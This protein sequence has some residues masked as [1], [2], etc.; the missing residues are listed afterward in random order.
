MIETDKVYTPSGADYTEVYNKF[1]KYDNIL[2]I[3]EG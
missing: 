2:N 3:R 1:V